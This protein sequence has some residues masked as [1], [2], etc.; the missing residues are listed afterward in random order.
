MR[1]T[2]I[3]FRLWVERLERDTQTHTHTRICISHTYA[4][5]YSYTH[6]VIVVKKLIMLLFLCAFPVPS[7]LRCL[8][9]IIM[10]Y[11]YTHTSPNTRIYIN[12]QT[13]LHTPAAMNIKAGN[14]ETNI[15]HYILPK[16]CCCSYQLTE[17]WFTARGE[18]T[19]KP[20][21]HHTLTNTHT[22]VYMH[23]KIAFGRMEEYKVDWGGTDN[24]RLIPYY[25]TAYNIPA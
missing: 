22:L 8:I 10:Q 23:V 18:K 17:H 1:A 4:P 16:C 20:K 6:W 2:L 5:P 7:H 12:V 13:H 11:I 9:T 19:R 24:D 3:V 15:K 21:T 25:S 14:K